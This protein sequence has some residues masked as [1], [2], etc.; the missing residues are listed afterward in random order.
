MIIIMLDKNHDGKSSLTIAFVLP[1]Y[2]IY[3]Y[4]VTPLELG[5]MYLF[6]LLN[7]VKPIQIKVILLHKCIHFFNK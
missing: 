4:Y 7:K 1:L 6:M 2:F 3:Y 5:Y